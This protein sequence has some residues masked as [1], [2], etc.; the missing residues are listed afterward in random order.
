M[1]NIAGQ[2]FTIKTSDILTRK[3]LETSMMPAGLANALSYEEFASM[4]WYFFSFFFR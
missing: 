4:F 1:R 2:V 3:E